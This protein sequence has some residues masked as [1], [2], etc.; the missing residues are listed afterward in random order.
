MARYD[1]I[2]LRFWRSS[3]S[4]GSQL[5]VRLQHLQ[6]GESVRFEDGES[7]LAYLRTLLDSEGESRPPTVVTRETTRNREE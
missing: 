6:S 5:A 3:R 7:L 2:L 4:E 1:S